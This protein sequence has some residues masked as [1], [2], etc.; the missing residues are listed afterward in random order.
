MKY[1]NSEDN[2]EAQL[3]QINY[4]QQIEYYK[5]LWCVFTINKSIKRLTFG[6]DGGGNILGVFKA[7]FYILPEE[8][9][10]IAKQKLKAGSVPSTLTDRQSL[11]L[12]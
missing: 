8:W 4:D 2:N 12:S 7:F 11:S 1:L 10:K 6:R 9:S 5:T 3:K